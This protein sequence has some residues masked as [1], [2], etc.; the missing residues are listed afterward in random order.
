MSVPNVSTGVALEY[1]A[2]V[3][4][5][6]ANIKRQ[7][8]ELETAA[9]NVNSKVAAFKLSGM[10]ELMYETDKDNS[11]F[12]SFGVTA[13]QGLVKS[14]NQLNDISNSSSA[15]SNEGKALLDRVKALFSGPNAS[16]YQDIG[17][18]LDKHS[19]AIAFNERL[20]AEKIASD[21]TTVRNTLIN[22]NM[23]GS[24]LQE[25]IS[26]MLSKP[27]T[28]YFSSYFSVNA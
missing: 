2:R 28:A 1:Y 18:E 26:S 6:Q 7:A 5:Q 20:F 19:G 27:A 23:L 13:L 11:A 24:V 21:P 15:L 8:T 16:A 3:S 14:Y 22:D 4:A 12:C 25:T 10:F 17:L 9:G